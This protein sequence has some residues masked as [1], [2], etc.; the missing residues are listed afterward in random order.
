MKKTNRYNILLWGS[1]DIFL[2]KMCELQKYRSDGLEYVQHD[3]WK[4][5]QLK[6]F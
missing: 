2:L 6:Y 4:L 3:T 1:S 5:M